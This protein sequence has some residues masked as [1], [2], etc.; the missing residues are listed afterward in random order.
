LFRLSHEERPYWQTPPLILH[1]WALMVQGSVAEGVAQME[2]GL[3]AFEAAGT[4]EAKPYYQSMLADGY[5]QVGRA[6]DA[7]EVL[8]DAL[9]VATLT[10][11]AW[12]LPE[13]Y[14]L[15]GESL[16]V[17]S[18]PL[19]AEAEASFQRALAF[20]Q[21]QGARALELRAAL[22]LYCLWH[23]VGRE[24]EGRAVLETVAG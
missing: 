18:T 14:R 12:W 7:L 2:R 1:G 6:E 11:E 17:L 24:D 16:L 22:S 19:P 9:A 5:L 10:G 3:S 20:A 23:G 15:R 13:L 4:V 21:R 8:A